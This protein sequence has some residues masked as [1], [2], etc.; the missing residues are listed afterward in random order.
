MWKLVADEMGI[1]WRSVGG[2]HWTMGEEEM[3]RCANV[4]PFS[5]TMQLS[6]S[7]T[8]MTVYSHAITDENGHHQASVYQ[9]DS[10]TLP[11]TRKPDG[12]VSTFTIDDLGLSREPFAG[13]RK[14]KVSATAFTGP[15]DDRHIYQARSQET[16]KESV[17]LSPRPHQ[18]MRNIPSMH[19]PIHAGERGFAT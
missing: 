2:M 8:T 14:Q 3:A 12:S 15:P 11:G 5:K 10:S 1:P 6:T 17:K 9:D 19:L 4:A 13:G 16:G 18:T 7:S